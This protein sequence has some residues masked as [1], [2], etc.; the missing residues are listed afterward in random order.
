[1]A[2]R[3]PEPPKLSSAEKA[4]IAADPLAAMVGYV[5]TILAV[6][7]IFEWMGLT[8]DQ[9]AILGGA[10]LGVAATYRSF[11]ERDHRK[12][13]ERLERE[14]VELRARQAA[15]EPAQD[16]GARAEGQGA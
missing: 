13:L 12:G 14:N 11:M 15:Q 5:S 9:V 4:R 16:E 8:A 1:M 3:I 2:T 7:G 6:F 10:V